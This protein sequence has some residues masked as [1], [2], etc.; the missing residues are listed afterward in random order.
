MYGL[1][2]VPPQLTEPELERTCT[3]VGPAASRLAMYSSGSTVSPSK[4]WYVSS[5]CCP[6]NCPMKLQER[7]TQDATRR[8][9]QARGG[10]GGRA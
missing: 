8:A 4:P 5:P 9:E 2:G 10:K 1:P 3:V 7:P 6:M